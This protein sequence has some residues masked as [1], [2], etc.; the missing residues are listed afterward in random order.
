MERKFFLCLALAGSTLWP[1]ADV[2][3]WSR[4]PDPALTPGPS[5]VT[6]PPTPTQP[7]PIRLSRRF[8][9]RTSQA[10]TAISQF[11]KVHTD[12]AIDASWLIPPTDPYRVGPG[13][14]MEIELME[15]PETHQT[16]MVLPDGTLFFHILAGLKVTGMTLEDIK[17][18]MEK[19]LAVDYRN[20]QVSI[21]LRAATN[22]K[23]WV[24]GRCKRPGV[25]TLE[26]PT[27]VL[28]ALSR[29]GGF[30]VARSA[31]DS[32]EIVDLPHA[33]LVRDGRFVPINFTRLVREGDT[34]QNIY[35][36]NNDSIFLPSAAGARAYVMGAVAAPRVVDFRDQL[37]LSAALANAGGFAPNAYPQHVVIIRDSLANPRVAVVNFNEIMHGKATDVLLEPKD[38]VWVPNSPFTRLDQYYHLIV[39]TFVR[40]VAANEGIRAAAPGKQS[41]GVNVSIGVQ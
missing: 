33:F 7:P 6:L 37:T 32:E 11:R 8:D 21:I 10:A 13:D 22:R 35:L 20:P 9:P 38:I 5:T 16:C 34:S 29:A 31:G 17:A 28:E 15:F 14:Q 41:T 30:E 12:A 19:A 4:A 2:R 1:R 23:I 3:A 26:G 27:T 25:Y 39:N 36:Q 24:L 18:A 40:T